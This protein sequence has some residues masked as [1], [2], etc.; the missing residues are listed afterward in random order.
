M[1]IEL[2]QN[3]L[4]TSDNSQFILKDVKKV[5]KADGTIKTS[6]R[7]LGYYGELKHALNAYISNV[8]RQTHKRKRCKN[9]LLKREQFT[10]T[11]KT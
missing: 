9:Y 8:H 1:R 3:T 10:N 5:K 7:V 2:D 6:E 11:L 4:L